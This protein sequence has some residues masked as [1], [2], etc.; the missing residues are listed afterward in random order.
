MSEIIVVFIF[1]FF[2]VC[3]VSTVC[4][5]IWLFLMRPHKRRN[6]VSVVRIDGDEN[7]ENL[8]YFIEKYR[9]YGRDYADY[10]IFV[11]D[12]QISQ[13]ASLYINEHKNI[14]CVKEEKL[15]ELLKKLTEEEYER[16]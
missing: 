2:S 14:Y 10:I 7:E 1:L 3:G 8:F 15:K 16:G 11:T 12:S 13:R 5:K 6:N 4:A 9:W